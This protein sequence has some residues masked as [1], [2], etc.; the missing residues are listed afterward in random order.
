MRNLKFTFFFLISFSYVLTAQTHFQI[1]CETDFDGQVVSGS[2]ATLIEE[3]RKGKPVRIGWQLD[4]NEDK[5]ADFDHW[6]DAEFITI[7]GEDV[8]TQI[9]NIN[10]QA[11]DLE[12]PQIDII[13]VSTMWTGVL[14]TNSILKN[15]FVYSK[16]LEFET[17]EEGNPIMTDEVEKDLARRE[18]QSWKVATFW[19]VPKKDVWSK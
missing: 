12:T 15:R 14:G 16:D 5:V 19:A 3:I 10:V 11:L 9:R 2:K 1:V 7:L 4:F 13:P 17:D 6:M 18:V 8:F